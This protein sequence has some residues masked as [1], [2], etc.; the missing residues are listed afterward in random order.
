M[1]KTL[2][3]LLAL[4]VA[5]PSVVQAGP[6]VV[7]Q[8]ASQ[9][10]LSVV[11]V[12]GYYPVVL[13]ALGSGQIKDGRPGGSLSA[14]NNDKVQGAFEAGSALVFSLRPNGAGVYLHYIL[15][16][17]EQIFPTE[18]TDY[19]KEYYFY[20]TMPAGELHIT[21]VFGYG[22]YTS[23]GSGGDNGNG[24]DNGGGTGG[25]GGSGG[26]GSSRPQTTTSPPQ[27]STPVPPFQ[28]IRR[29]ET[30]TPAAEPP[31]L[32]WWS[33]Q[34]LLGPRSADTWAGLGD[35]LA[36]LSDQFAGDIP[37]LV[38]VP[39]TSYQMYTNVPSRHPSNFVAVAMDVT[40]QQADQQFMVPVRFMGNALTM[41]VNW[42]ADYGLAFISDQRYEDPDGFELPLLRDLSLLFYS[43][44]HISFVNG[45][46]SPLS[47]QSLIHHSRMFITATDTEHSFNLLAY[48]PEHHEAVIFFVLD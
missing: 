19:G 5:T 45:E 40:P 47:Q 24:D 1:K 34:V 31:R 11:A 15:V 48:W 36:Y 26:G 7:Q 17:G 16:N 14:T 38:I 3:Y 10:G 21:A 6:V 37:L 32:P 22:P 18:L 43:G 46:L 2:S 4:A 41:Q 39:E 25:S 23:N 33:P 42:Q 27:A 13:A 12:N 30:P 9:D 20:H 29:P 8:M 35:L 28:P 44:S